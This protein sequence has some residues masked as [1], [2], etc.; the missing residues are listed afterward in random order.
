MILVSP[1]FENLQN[2]SWQDTTHWKSSRDGKNILR[3]LKR[4]DD[5]S[6]ITFNMR[7]RGI[8]KMGRLL[9]HKDSDIQRSLKRISIDNWTNLQK[10]PEKD[11]P[12]MI[13]LN[14]EDLLPTIDTSLKS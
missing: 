7:R 11:L 13:S 1:K 4:F 8:S 5:L 14:T 6:K 12:R 9:W 3:F 2:N 10:V